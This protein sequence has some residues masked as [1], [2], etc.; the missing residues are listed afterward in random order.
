MVLRLTNY[1]TTR[2]NLTAA[3]RSV[4]VGG[5]SVKYIL[6]AFGTGRGGKGRKERKWREA[7]GRGR[8]NVGEGGKRNR[9]SG[10]GSSG[11]SAFTEVVAGHLRLYTRKGSAFGIWDAAMFSSWS[12]GLTN[13]G[14]V[15][16]AMTARILKEHRRNVYAVGGQWLVSICILRFERVANKVLHW[17]T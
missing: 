14:S 6:M 3:P 1:G 8:K 15:A 2:V 7:L 17:T 11:V 16:Y 13:R 12:F 10:G 5:A 4:K 9:W